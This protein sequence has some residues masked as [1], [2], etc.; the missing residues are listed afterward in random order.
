[1]SS[2]VSVPLAPLALATVVGLVAALLSL[3]SAPAS[4]AAAAGSPLLGAPKAGQCYKVTNRV[5]FKGVSAN[6]APINCSKRHNL[7]VTG[8]YKVPKNL[9]MKF[10]NRKFEIFSLNACDRSYR[11][12]VGK[13]LNFARS[14]YNLFRFLPTQA[15][16]NQGARWV[17]CLVGINQGADRLAVTKGKLRKVGKKM[18]PRITHCVTKGFAS[19]NC[20]AP[21]KYHPVYAVKV[22]VG[23]KKVRDRALKVCTKRLGRHGDWAASWRWTLLPGSQ[24]GII[25]LRK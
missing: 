1:M 21:H 12:K 17:S 10:G 9:K 14:A 22:K 3:L 15:Q 6:K 20:A 19:T 13:G 8:V 5:A 18:P 25:C 23:S 11:Q 24:W 7:A 2:R 4:S 16:Q